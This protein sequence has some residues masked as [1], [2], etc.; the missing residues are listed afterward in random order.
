MYDL[1]SDERIGCSHN[2]VQNISTSL[3]LCQMNHYQKDD[4]LIQMS[5]QT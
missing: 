4:V 3:E 5:K 2:N 1:I